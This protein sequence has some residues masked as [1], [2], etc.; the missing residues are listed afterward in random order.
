ESN[1]F[2][3]LKDKN[4][5]YEIIEIIDK[6]AA[7]EAEYLS[8]IYDITLALIETETISKG[9][10]TILSTI[11][12]YYESDRVG[13][14]VY[15]SSKEQVSLKYEY[16]KSGIDSIMADLQNNNINDYPFL[17]DCYSRLQKIILIKQPTLIIKTYAKI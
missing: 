16:T 15:D 17:V 7:K 14:L 10:N 4:Y 1:I 5:T 9:I 13:M 3:L 6:T 11:G 2:M 12:L 8:A